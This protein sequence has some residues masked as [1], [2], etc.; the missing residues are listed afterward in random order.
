MHLFP[1]PSWLK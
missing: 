1:L